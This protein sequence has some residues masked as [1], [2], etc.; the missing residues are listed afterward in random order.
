MYGRPMGYLKYGHEW[1]QNEPLAIEM[2]CIQNGG[3][4]MEGDVQCGEGLFHH[5]RSMWTLCWPDQDNHRWSDTI[6]NSYC[7]HDITAITGCSDSS[8]THSIAKIVLSDY[9]CF[10]DKTLW[11]VSTTEGRGSELRVWGVI[12]DLFNEA[13]KRFPYLPGNPI[14]YL[15][16]ITSGVIDKEK[17]SSRSLRRGVIVIPCKSGGTTSGL[18]SFIGIKAPRLRHA[19]DETQCMN[20]AFLNAYSN[21]VG[22][23]D[24]KG[25]MAGNFMEMDDPLGVA[26]EP[27]GGWDTFQDAG[28]TQTWKSRFYDANVIALDGRD[29]PNFDFPDHLERTHF[30]Y[31]IGHKKLD[32]VA[33]TKGTNS[34]E[35]HSQCIGKPVRGMDVWR[36]MT[37]DFCIKHKSTEDV[38]WREDPI[39]LYALD[40]A[41]GAGDRCV[42]RRG[43]LGFNTEGKQIL[44]LHEPEIIPIHLGTPV[45]PEDQIAIYVANRL[46]ELGIP[47]QHCFYDSFGRGTLGYCFARLM[48]TSTPIPVDSSGQPTKR[49]V[50]FDLFVKNMDGS[51][52][53]K[54]CDEHYKK[55]ITELWF[56]LREAIDAEQIRGL[57]LETIREGSSR[58]FTKENNLIILEPKD[59]MKKRTNGKSPDL[60]DTTAILCEGARQL[61]FKIENIGD[62]V[63][64]TKS[65]KP[66]TLEIAAIEYAEM[67]KSRQLSERV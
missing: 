22:K 45:E 42:G 41:Y 20:D 12:K 63:Q 37:K 18:A 21:W 6:L 13:R 31:L 32:L 48:G 59:E 5:Y 15:K 10:P 2:K 1:K 19:G 9:W 14:D 52:R 26:T 65:N 4:W 58:K 57:D 23:E 38:I 46:K 61:G 49:P 50:R 64:K 43:E 39:Q 33:K 24:F 67:L 8:K 25:L 28:R 56:S 44:Y 35:W 62:E 54:R 16:T 47:P 27:E 29:S 36:V 40:P 11:L 3:K 55:F 66:D 60:C 17:F 34:W 53:L 30:P 7:N 51:Q